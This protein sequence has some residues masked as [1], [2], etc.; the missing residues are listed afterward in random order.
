MWTHAELKERARLAFMKNRWQCILVT[1]LMTC[2]TVI[3]EI[4]E[5][6]QN[7]LN[8]RLAVNGTST[9]SSIVGSTLNVRTL[10]LVGGALT[11][12][13]IVCIFLSIFVGNVLQVGG[14]SFFVRNQTAQPGVRDML[15]V[16]ESGH[17]TNIVTTMFLK[18]IYI[19]LWSLLLIIPGIIKSYE[20]FMVPYILA[21]QPEIDTKDAFALS[22]QMMDGQKMNTF[23]L[24]LSFFGWYI[25]S[26]LTFGILGIFYVNPYI[27]STLAEL[28]TVL[29]Q[30]EY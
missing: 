23:I 26:A 14:K 13:S 10:S 27:E 11:F 16:F 18:D 2:I 9:I 12:F 19:Y 3:A 15:E 28:Y 4:S 30:K 7:G 22:K 25:L 20:Y 8:E 5:K 1:F 24:E 6:A 29:K 21:D 17:Y